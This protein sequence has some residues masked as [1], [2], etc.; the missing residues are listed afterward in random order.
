[1]IIRP[2]PSLARTLYLQKLYLFVCRYKLFLK[3]HIQLNQLWLLKHSQISGYFHD[4]SKEWT[5]MLKVFPNDDHRSMAHDRKKIES[6]QGQ[7]RHE[8]CDTKLY[9]M[10][11]KILKE[12]EEGIHTSTIYRILTVTMSST[13]VLALL[14]RGNV[15]S[16][17]FSSLPMRKSCEIR[18]EEFRCR[19]PSCGYRLRGV[20]LT[21]FILSIRIWKY[22]DI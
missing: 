16:L 3:C 19:D 22:R 8:I 5:I 4:F 13:S 20:R 21:S 9:W 14:D 17:L 11:I 2:R 6:L 1:M 15:Y 10:E 12:Q 18:F 7:Y